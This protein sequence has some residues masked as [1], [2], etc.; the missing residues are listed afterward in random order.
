[1]YSGSLQCGSSS[2]NILITL[3][4]SKVFNSFYIQLNL[5]IHKGPLQQVYMHLDWN[6][7]FYS[8]K[9]DKGRVRKICTLKQHCFLGLR[10]SV[11]V[12]LK[13]LRWSKSFS[14]SIAGKVLILYYT[15]PS[16]PVSQTPWR[17]HS[18]MP[19]LQLRLSRPFLSG[20]IS[21]S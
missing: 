12:I 9:S 7:T 13:S 6:V 19:A 18:L 10:S 8:F 17:I 2:W 11:S 3:W 5:D 20:T 15:T 4:V 21:V 16:A 14:D 1:M